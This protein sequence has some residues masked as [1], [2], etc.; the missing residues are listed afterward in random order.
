MKFLGFSLIIISAVSFGLI[1]IFATFA[2]K[3]GLSIEIILFFYFLIAAILL[4][5]YIFIKKYSYPKGKLL[6]ILIFIG[7]ILYSAQALKGLNSIVALT[8]IISSAAFVYASY[9]VYSH[10]K[11]PSNLQ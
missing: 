7:A 1:P 9:R 5:L 10:A 8:V 4:N 6:V 11:I 2:Y 3:N